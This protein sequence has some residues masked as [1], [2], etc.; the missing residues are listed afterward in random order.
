MSTTIDNRVVEMQFENSQFEKGVSKSIK[1]IE[2]LKKS[3]KFDEAT[4]N[5]SQLQKAGDSFSLA[6]IADAAED[7]AYRFSWMGRTV[8]NVL[9]N[10]TYRATSMVKSLSVDQITSGWTKYADKTAYV[11]TIMNATG[12]SIDEV[13][14]YLSKLMWFSDE[15]SYSF[16]DMTQALGTLT[17]SGGD[18]DKL[19]PML[20]GMANATSFAG[21]SAAE[22]SRTM[23][24]LNQSYS[25]GY[26]QYIDWKSVEMAG[27]GSEQLKQ[28]FIDAGIA[29]GKLTKD[30]KTTK[31][32]LVSIAN[33]GSTLNEKWADTKV[34]ERAFGTFSEMTEKAYELIQEGK[35]DTASEAYEYLSTQY[36]GIGITA[37]KAAQEAKSFNEAIAATTDA[38]SSGWMNTFELIFG[39]YDEAKVMWTD[40]ANWLW[41]V[42]ASGAEARNELL[43]TWKDLGG[44]T[45]MLEGIYSLFDSITNLIYAMKDAW[46]S[47]FP[48]TTADQLM[49]I[50][51]GIKSIGDRI[52]EAFS[53]ETATNVVDQFTE[54]ITKS[55]PL[56]TFWGEMEK[57][58]KG[59]D[60]KK[61]QERLQQLGYDIGETGV[62]GI[63]GSKTQAALV[64]FQKDSKIKP[65]GIFDEKTFDKLSTAISSA[66]GEHT[67]IAVGE[68]TEEVTTYASTL[69][70]LRAIAQGAFSVLHI[71]WTTIKFLAQAAGK[72]LSVFAP[73]GN[74]VLSVFAKLAGVATD[75]DQALSENGFVGALEKLDNFLEPL[76][77]KVQDFAD[78]IMIFFGLGE[79]TEAS[80]GVQKFIDIFSSIKDWWDSLEITEK[81][82]NAFTALKDA[83][84]EAWPSVKEFF[85]TIGDLV[86]DKVSTGFSIVVD[87]LA[88]KIPV[89]I[90]AV[91][92]AF[93]WLSD[94]IKSLFG[95]GENEEDNPI[96]ETVDG[97]TAVFY[98]DG[99]TESK[100]DKAKS[101]IEKIKEFFTSIW[102]TVGGFFGDKADKISNLNPLESLKTLFSSIGTWLD[103]AFS[104]SLT[105]ILDGL[106]KVMDFLGK[107]AGWIIGGAGILI[108]FKLIK[109]VLGFKDL[110]KEIV[111]LKKLEA[112]AEIAKNTDDNKTAKLILSIAVSIGIIA[113]A[114][115]MLGSM[116]P[117]ELTKG[118]IGIAA[119]VAVI[120]GLAITFAIIQKKY[121]GIDFK[122]I[123]DAIFNIGVAVGIIAA[124]IFVLGNM[125]ENQLKQGIIALGIMLLMLVGVVYVFKKLNASVGTGIELKGMLELAGAIA[126]MAGLAIVLGFV[127]FWKFMSGLIKL[128]LVAGLM[129][130]FVVAVT[131]VGK[132]SANIQLSGL[133]KISFAIGILA[134]MAWI[135]GNAD[136]GK[137]WR[138]FAR[139][140]AVSGL[141]LGFVIILALI[142]KKTNGSIDIAVKGLVKMS[143][144]IA[145]LSGIAWIL[146]KM[147]KN[148]L[149]Q[150]LI[151]MS[152]IATILGLLIAVAGLYSKDIK[153]GP[154][155]A[156][157]LGFAA[158]V[159]AFSFAISNIKDVKWEVMLSFAASMGIALAALVAACVVA[160]KFGAGTMISGSIGIAAALAI[161]VGVITLI[162][163]GLGEIDKLTN[164]GLIEALE[165]GG[166]VMAAVGSAVGKLV[167]GIVS[168]F[169]SVTSTALDELSVS[170]D[171]FSS[172][173]NTLKTTLSGISEDTKL[174][175]DATK[176][177]DIATTIKG[178][179]DTIGLETDGVSTEKV[180]NFNNRVESIT[181]SLG[182]FGTSIGSIRSGIS[183]VSGDGDIDADV[184]KAI[185]VA[186]QIK[187]GFFDKIGDDALKMSSD[188]LDEYNQQVTSVLTY[189]DTFSTNMANL[190]EDLGGMSETEI[191]ADTATALAC[192]SKV[193]KFLTDI[194]GDEY[195]IEQGNG[196][197]LSFFGKKTESETLID[198]IS[199]MGTSIKTLKNDI[200][201]L[202]SNDFD[203]DVESMMA[204][205]NSIA[206]FVNKVSAVDFNTSWNGEVE[207]IETNVGML[208]QGIKDFSTK[209]EG[210][211][212]AA[213]T[214]VANAMASAMDSVMDVAMPDAAYRA[215]SYLGLFVTVGLNIAAG[216]AQ[217]IRDNTGLVVSAAENLARETL[218]E[219]KEEFNEHSP[220]KKFEEIGLFADKGLERGISE[221]TG[222]VI[223]SARSMGTSALDAARGSLSGL[224]N[225]LMNNMDADPV[226]RPVVDMSNV[227]KSANQIDGLV[228]G[229]RAININTTV[230]QAGS[231]SRIMSRSQLASQN[232]STV[233]NSVGADSTNPV[234]VSGNNFYIR[235][236]NDVK[237]L[238]HELATLTRQQQR[239]LGASY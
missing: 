14:G 32:T 212:V 33:F 153:M 88:E 56:G 208:A 199:E 215:S 98:D 225:V 200:E 79:N 76:R 107:H 104:T 167:G 228:S 106:G 192:A 26:M 139:L 59:D 152:V 51:N 158:I 220:S 214:S 205:Y 122:Q 113:L 163:A 175:T 125:G 188:D 99:E 39:N 128:T 154:I 58:A 196:N 97:F 3:L 111:G 52:K 37:A 195:N 41:D 29:E 168:G 207:S 202:S 2:E 96:K 234:N 164:G 15:T 81:L 232:G 77:Q 8:S 203:S 17:S 95:I 219:M 12:K 133:L 236:D 227:N 183:G 60:V 69:D 78:A 87:W 185:H 6:K 73:L 18:I 28:A 93:Q 169:S 7:L 64:Q 224:A 178:F 170:L 65:T 90:N 132:G 166:D 237:M 23:Y 74:V 120:A 85:T 140:L 22:F 112:K 92:G 45:A 159:L 46:A 117:G 138:G 187:E 182:T 201:G 19:I 142:S 66:F 134:A 24:N 141:L 155:I 11:Q 210:V 119:C 147:D 102:D 63:F 162:V 86:G 70:K 179:F 239:S 50:S 161:I 172:S 130:G 189:T 150:G 176:A 177:I 55:D 137:W 229:S 218:A 186:T 67:M 157:A 43:Q 105:G 94:T 129:I 82:S 61:L 127:D 135:L 197:F 1:S 222:S 156:L 118:I 223:D 174:E 48:E 109:F 151:A 89:A 149:M 148:E 34:M 9:D 143:L 71:G 230:A 30:A 235:S 114:M 206:D 221:G 21:K 193:A 20:E 126:I 145:I 180:D 54:A 204:A 44:R 165:R 171:N 35:F 190:R 84:V 216:L 209:T 27:V 238:A 100:L 108:L 38:V 173:F 213:V 146:G 62:D 31:G 103:T 116:S 144:A 231:V 13:N 91:V 136:P 110:A 10:I 53:Y 121:S 198:D 5:L 115:K 16:V 80:E 36:T 124:S 160:G 25:A 123:T 194:T 211:D 57:G 191:E 47:V 181:T 184:E 40:L 131:K 75:A 49:D 83:V 72:V 226:I 101:F 4:E 42:F 233:Q 68:T 217:G